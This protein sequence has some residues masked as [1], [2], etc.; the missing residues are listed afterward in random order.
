MPA[1]Y[2]KTLALEP[3]IEMMQAERNATANTIEAY[4]RDLT[5]L[6][7]FLD[8]QCKSTLDE[9]LQADLQ[10]F[11]R[12]QH[13]QGMAAATLSRKLSS[14]RQYYRFLV[15][16]EV[17]NDD[18]TISLSFPR[19]A[20]T[21]PK[22]LSI[23]EVDH[24]LTA[25]QADESPEGLRL[26]AFLET[27]YAT[28]LRVS[29]IVSLELATVMQPAT[30]NQIREFIIVMG[31]G[32]KERM[33]PLNQSSRTALANY[34]AARHQF[35]NSKNN[36]LFPSSAKQGYLTR[37]R[38]G[39]LLKQL[40]IE[41]GLPPDKLSPHV[42]RHSFASHLLHCGADLR[43]IQ[44]L[45]GHSDISTTQIYTHVLNSRMKELVLTHHP[46]AQRG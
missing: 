36:Y 18:P 33:V 40:A 4:Q 29:E 20:K 32:R 22:Y 26:V 8:K 14:L 31:K 24:L 38:L 25:A 2:V 27:L 1:S 34:I 15:A 37:Q 3:F 17:R 13:K 41:S 21:L 46:L 35:P 5:E 10:A 12:Y 23:E 45:L 44:E 19:Q 42:L 6:I 7:F 39:Q 16:E 9:A 43:V 11:M 28:G 30:S